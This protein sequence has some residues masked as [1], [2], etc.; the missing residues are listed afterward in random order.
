MDVFV[1]GAKEENDHLDCYQRKVQNPGLSWYD[2][3]IVV[4]CTSVIEPL[5]LKH[6]LYK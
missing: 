2:R 5:G 1:L 4:T 6:T 3:V